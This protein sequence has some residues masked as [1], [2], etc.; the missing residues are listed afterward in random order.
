MGTSEGAKKGWTE[1]RRKRQSE[2]LRRQR[3]DPEWRAAQ[4]ERTRQQWIGN[5]KRKA[6]LGR[7][8]APRNMERAGEC[9]MSISVAPGPNGGDV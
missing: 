1:E 3:A 9:V 5:D 6:E 4:A 2:T 7:V 8:V